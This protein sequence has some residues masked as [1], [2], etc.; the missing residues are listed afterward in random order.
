MIKMISTAAP[1]TQTQGSTVVVSVVVVL[2]R[3]LLVVVLAESCASRMLLISISEN[4][5]INDLPVRI[6]V[7]ILI[8]LRVRPALIVRAIDYYH[9]TAR[10]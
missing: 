8:G 1:T 2:L 7:F 10:G 4:V 5:A 6:K 9:N 3:V